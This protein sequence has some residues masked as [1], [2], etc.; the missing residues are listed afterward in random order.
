MRSTGAQVLIVGGGPVGLAVAIDLGKRGISSILVEERGTVSRI[1]RVTTVNTLG[2]IHCR[3]WGV[4][5]QVRAAGWPDDYPLDI[6]FTTSLTGREITRFSIPSHG[7]TP[8]P[9]TVPE[10]TQT[11]PQHWF[12]PIMLR[13]AQAIPNI[14]IR[15]RHR[16][17][18]FSENAD[19]VLAQINDLEGGEVLEISADYLLACDGARSTV[20]E[21]LGIEMVGEDHDHNVHIMFRAPSL[22]ARLAPHNARFHYLMNSDG[23]EFILHMIDGNEEW[24][25]AMMR[26]AEPPDPASIDIAT[27]L[28]RVVGESFDYEVT[29]IDLWQ[30]STRS[31]A[32]YGS[33]RIFLVGDAAHT[34]SPNGGFGMN[35]GLAD[36]AN[37]AWKLAARL[38]GWGGSNL[39]SS[40]DA[41]RRPV[42]AK[43]IAEARNN[44]HRLGGLGDLTYID[45]DG[46]G[47]ERTRAELAAHLQTNNR[48]NHETVGTELNYCYDGSPIVI[49]D[50]TAAPKATHHTYVPTARPGHLAPHAWLADG[51]STHDLFCEGFTLL[52]LGATE[53]DFARFFGPA[54][55]SGMP[56]KIV[57]IVDAEIAALYEM[58]LV[59]VRPDGHVAW[60]GD[61]VPNDGMAVIDCVRGA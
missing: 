8:L 10:I 41:E 29:G 5:D 39:L 42:C 27:L 61:T 15:H 14:D 20:R 59:L 9:E 48:R 12:D 19:G 31:A 24:R 51:R 3:R 6:V 26:Y 22:K 17:V 43:V 21:A 11:C 49:S 4:V 44:Y 53:C 33:S 34:W 57:T 38:D 30:R 2:M 50:G 52:Q 32:R 54:D 37:I 1:P 16:L 28:R 7:A 46:P 45:D 47:G 35:T 36:A 55:G 18:K 40:Y 25:L 23:I 60:R 58:P 56:L 13:A